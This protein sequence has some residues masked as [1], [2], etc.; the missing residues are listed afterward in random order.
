MRKTSSCSRPLTRRQFLYYSALA[1]GATAFTGRVS[2]RPGTRR[3]SPNEKLN[4]AIIG[5]GGRGAADTAEV[6][7]E[8]IVALCDVNEDH[9]NA[10]AAKYPQARKYVDFRKLYDASKDIDAVVVATTEHT[11]A[12]AVMPA[13]HLGKH[14]FCEKPLA[15]S[16]WEARRYRPGGHQ[17]RHRH[18]NGNPN[19]RD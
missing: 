1:A 19:S 9:L 4:I 17:G 8:N 11:H 16:V 5:A 6:S 12:F 13:I 10:A 2:A 15:H 3:V 7:S 14:V 18:A